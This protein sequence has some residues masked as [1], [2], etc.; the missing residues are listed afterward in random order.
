[1]IPDPNILLSVAASAAAAAVSPNGNKTLLANE[2]NAY[3]V[4]ANQVFSSGQKGLLQN[5]RVN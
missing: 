4:K 1:M 3:R 2:L 5:L